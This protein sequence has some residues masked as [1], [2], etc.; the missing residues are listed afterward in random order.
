MVMFKTHISYG[1]QSGN[2]CIFV[3]CASFFKTN[4]LSNELKDIEIDP[5]PT[6]GNHNS[7]QSFVNLFLIAYIFIFFQRVDMSFVCD[8]L[9]V[10][11]SACF[12]VLCIS[13]KFSIFIKQYV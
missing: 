1:E 6:G 8:L 10:I 12:L 5:F 4:G 9:L 7:I 11:L 2:V 3:Y 13:C